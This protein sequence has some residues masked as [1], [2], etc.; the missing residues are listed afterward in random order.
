MSH[1]SKRRIRNRN[2][3]VKLQRTFT[4]TEHPPAR[5]TF[6][7]AARYDMVPFVACSFSK[8]ASRSVQ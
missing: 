6:A 4:G 7:K 5:H 8:R 2:R 1:P 3:S